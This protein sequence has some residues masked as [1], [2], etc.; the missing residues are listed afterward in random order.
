LKAKEEVVGTGI[1]TG[2]F[3]TKEEF[4]EIVKAI[5]R[6]KPI[7][8]TVNRNPATQSYDV[9]QK[10]DKTPEELTAD[11]AKAYKLPEARYGINKFRE[12]V[13]FTPIDE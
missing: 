2:V 4:R 13:L 11:L 3:V 6:Q 8:T 5:Y 9:I 7:E 10:K 1:G 12:F